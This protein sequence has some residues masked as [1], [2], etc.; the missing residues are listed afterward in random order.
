MQNQSILKAP[1]SDSFLKSSNHLPQSLQSIFNPDHLTREYLELVEIGRTVLLKTTLLQQQH[2][3]ELTRSQSKS[4]LWM[5]FR[6]GRVTSSRFYHA[7]HTSPQKP[8][9]SLVIGTCY[10]D[11]VKFTSAATQYGLEHEMAGI[12]AYKL[13]QTEHHTDLKVTPAGFIVSIKKPCF[14]ASP[15]SF[16]ECKCCGRGVL[17][18]KCPYTAREASS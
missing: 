17:E 14:G 8:A 11:S 16:V 7:V 9:L 15:D 2:L 4:K 13:L 12:E 18:V 5:E 10:P 1:Y 3:E 6:S